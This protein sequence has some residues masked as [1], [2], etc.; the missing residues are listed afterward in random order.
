MSLLFYPNRAEGWISPHYFQTGYFSMKKVVWRFPIS[1]LFLIHYELSEN[2]K[3]NFW[4]FTVFW[5]D[6]EGAGWISPPP[7]S[8]NIQKPRS[9]R[10]N[11]DIFVLLLT[12]RQNVWT[13]WEYLLVVS[14]TDR[15][16]IIHHCGYLFV[17]LLTDR[18]NI[19][20]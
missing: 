10:V 9:I 19:W 14:L 15:R 3:K 7:L 1:W 13:Y 6:L 8:S 20:T 4:F 18:Q 17:M 11:I 5:G 16:N 12:D 2:Q